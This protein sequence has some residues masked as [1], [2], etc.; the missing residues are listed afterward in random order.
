MYDIERLKQQQHFKEDKFWASHLN[1]L[2]ENNMGMAGRQVN[3]H[4]V[5]L[6]DGEQTSNL[7]FSLSD[8]IRIAE[9]LDDLGVA[10]IEAGMPIISEE[11][12]KGIRK[13]VDQNFNSD[14]VGVELIRIINHEVE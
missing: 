8:R 3:I 6:R 10:R 14:V 5:T 11:V 12:R 9:A 1:F 4:D 2:P 7:A 13:M